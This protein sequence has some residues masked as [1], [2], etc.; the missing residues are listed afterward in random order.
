MYSVQVDRLA[1]LPCRLVA[2]LSRWIGGPSWGVKEDW[3]NGT[4]WGWVGGWKVKS[5]WGGGTSGNW[6]PCGNGDA[7]NGNGSKWHGIKSCDA[8]LTITAL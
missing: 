4:F 8:N 5:G 6:P 7:S 3:G 2:L 1:A